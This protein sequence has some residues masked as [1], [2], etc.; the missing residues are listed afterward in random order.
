M[1]LLHAEQRGVWQDENRSARA[2]PVLSKPG[3]GKLRPDHVSVRR[4]AGPVRIEQIVRGQ[5]ILG[6]RGV[7]RAPKI[8][9]YYRGAAGYSG[10]AHSERSKRESE[11]LPAKSLMKAMER[12][13]S[14]FPLTAN[15][16]K[17]CSVG[18]RFCVPA[19]RPSPVTSRG[20][21]PG[22]TDWWSALVLSVRSPWQRKNKRVCRVCAEGA[23]GSA[24]YNGFAVGKSENYRPRKFR[25]TLM[26]AP[27]ALFSPS[28]KD[29]DE[30]S[31]HRL[32]ESR[33]ICH[34]PRCGLAVG[35]CRLTSGESRT[36]G[37][38]IREGM[39]PQQQ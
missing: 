22:L 16:R 39:P 38:I 10:F 34:E 13:F 36:R 29:S 1:A 27:E 8:G 32:C 24:T 7:P 25:Q 11:A 20:A 23:S 33:K 30:G 4:G 12:R 9:P 26:S 2:V 5:P 21:P 17:A 28:T 31:Q 37:W 14:K 15:S 6:I 3:S 19:H 18:L 35:Q